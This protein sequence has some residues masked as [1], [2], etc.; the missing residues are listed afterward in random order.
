MLKKNKSHK[1]EWF[2][3]KKKQRVSQISTQNHWTV[4]TGW[5]VQTTSEHF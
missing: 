4:A 2:S 1:K 5:E 3:Y